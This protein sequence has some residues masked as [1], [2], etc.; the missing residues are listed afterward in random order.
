MGC[1][2][3][4][5]EGT[6]SKLFPWDQKPKPSNLAMEA[7]LVFLQNACKSLHVKAKFKQPTILKVNKSEANCTAKRVIIYD[8]NSALRNDRAINHQEDGNNNEQLP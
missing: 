2:W 8:V 5:Q 3:I 7:D 6:L 1:A 4:P